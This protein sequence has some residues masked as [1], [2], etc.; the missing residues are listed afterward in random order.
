VIAKVVPGDQPGEA[1]GFEATVFALA[2]SPAG[3]TYRRSARIRCSPLW[4]ELNVPDGLF[5]PN[6]SAARARPPA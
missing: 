4:V 3:A 5:S 2:F 1:E 6:Q